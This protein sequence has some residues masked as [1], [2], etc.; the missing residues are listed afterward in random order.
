MTAIDLS[1]E[2]LIVFTAFAI[3]CNF[4]IDRVVI[5]KVSKIDFVVDPLI[6]SV[7]MTT[8]AVCKRNCKNRD[9]NR[10]DGYR[11]RCCNEHNLSLCALC[12]EI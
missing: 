10:Y 2:E 4:P 11:Y 8:A 7:R 12:T 3:S 6:I 5:P 9:Q 1:L